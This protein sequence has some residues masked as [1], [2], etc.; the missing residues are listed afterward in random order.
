MGAARCAA[1]DLGEKLVRAP[2]RP[3]RRLDVGAPLETER[4]VGRQRQPLARA[5]HRDGIEPRAL[6]RGA[7]RPCAYLGIGP[8]HH[9]RHRLRARPVGDDEHVVRQGA[10][11][12]V[13]GPNR[14]PGP[15]AADPQLAACEPVEVERVHRLA[16]LDH[17]VIRDVDDVVDGPDAGRFEPRRHPGRRRSDCHLG[18]RRGV[19][20]AEGAGM[21]LDRDRQ[22]VVPGRRR[23]Q[24][25][26]SDRPAVDRRHL[27]GDPGDAQAVGAVGRD[28]QI[29]DRVLAPGRASGNGRRRL[30]RRHLEPVRGERLGQLIDAHRDRHE[31]TQPRNQDFQ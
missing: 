24:G 17:H 2:H 6:E 15:R 3:H 9:T 22:C 7:Y 10:F 20:W 30:D 16:Q 13:E 31:L 8:A 5:A 19:P 4:R 26:P 12:A 18:H 21:L 11:D 14:F 27:A 1:A 28:F 23:G 29:E 25:R